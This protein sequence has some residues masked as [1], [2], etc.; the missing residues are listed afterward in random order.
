MRASL[1]A[2]RVA[3]QDG[4]TTDGSSGGSTQV[5]RQHKGCAMM[6]SCQGVEKSSAGCP[7]HTQCCHAHGRPL[8]GSAPHP[9][10]VPQHDGFVCQL[11]LL[12]VVLILLRTTHTGRHQ[13]VGDAKGSE[14]VG[15]GSPTAECRWTP[16]PPSCCRSAATRSCH[17]GGAASPPPPHRSVTHVEAEALEHVLAL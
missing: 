2:L 14:L 8:M 1:S 5:R 12:E 11:P 9:P 13:R 7:R 15:L 3:R 16:A 6:G 4:G 17:T 10:L